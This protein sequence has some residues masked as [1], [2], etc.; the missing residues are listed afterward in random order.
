MKRM[1]RISTSNILMTLLLLLSTIFSQAQSAS[2]VNVNS[3]GRQLIEENGRHF[4]MIGDM[5][6]ELEGAGILSVQIKDVQKWPNGIVPVTFT[7]NYPEQQRRI[8]LESCNWWSKA[9]SIKCVSRTNEL[10]YILI[11]ASNSINNSFVGMIGGQQV[12]NLFNRNSHG[13]I[14]HELAHALGF[15]HQHNSPNRDQFVEIVWGNIKTAAKHNFR[16]VKKAVVF[17]D[18]DFCSV[19]HYRQTAFSTNGNNTIN[20]KATPPNCRIG[21]RDFL[22]NSDKLGMAG[23]YGQDAGDEKISI[24]PDFVGQYSSP[25]EFSSKNAFARFGIRTEIIDGGLKTGCIWHTNCERTCYETSA[26]WQYPDAGEKVPF[27]TVISLKTKID[28]DAQFLPPPRG[29]QCQ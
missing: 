1:T 4:E 18:Y 26:A 23:A 25:H 16:I 11:N 22:S 5:I 27:G 15:A 17:G 10:N 20:V 12:I 7:P 9:S 29:Q 13:V 28:A 3:G 24:V 19:M 8:F 14:A 21:Q 6:F 2:P